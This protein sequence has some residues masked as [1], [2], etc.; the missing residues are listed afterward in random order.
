LRLSNR[1]EPTNLVD[2]QYSIPYCLGLAAILGPS[3]LLPLTK[4]ILFRD[5]V[6][7]FARKVTLHLDSALD[8]R[9]P[10]ETL[11]RVVVHCRGERYESAVTAPRGEATDPLSWQ[12]LE[13]KFLTASRHIAT[14]GQQ[15]E[16]LD[17]ARQLKDG[18][19]A[20]LMACLSQMTFSGA[21]AL[22]PG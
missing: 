13:E 11:T 2:V 10:A 5:D 12:E 1:T 20:P 3:A 14:Q 15:A 22:K 19:I 17:A 4:D 16:I 18:D 7:Q 9:F 6:S 21:T 8:E